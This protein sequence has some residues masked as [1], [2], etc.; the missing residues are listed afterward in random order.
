MGGRVRGVVE[1]LRRRVQQVMHRELIGRGMAVNLRGRGKRERGGVLYG[2]LQEEDGPADVD[3]GW[4]EC[5][6]LIP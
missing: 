3:A 2:E 1:R 5:N 6:G 4:T